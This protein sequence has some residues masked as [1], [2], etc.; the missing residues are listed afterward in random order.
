MAEESRQ[1]CPRH[2]DALNLI[3]ALVDLGDLCVAHHAFDREVDGVAGAAEQLTALVVTSIATWEAKHFAADEI[4]LS[5]GS[6]R[7][8]RAAAVYTINRAA[9]T[10]IAMALY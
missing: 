5:V 4:K 8:A 3:G 7:R 1:Q 6:P 2:D 10:F 9:S